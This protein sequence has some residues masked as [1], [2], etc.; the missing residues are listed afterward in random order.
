MKNPKRKSPTAQNPVNVSDQWPF[1]ATDLTSL[2]KLVNRS[3]REEPNAVRLMTARKINQI[4][5]ALL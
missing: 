3:P 1:P 2:L 5:D 4:E